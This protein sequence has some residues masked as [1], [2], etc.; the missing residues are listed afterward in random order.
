MN[1]GRCVDRTSSSQRTGGRVSDGPVLHRIV[2][3]NRPVGLPLLI[4]QGHRARPRRRPNPREA[5]VSARAAALKSGKPQLAISTGERA[6]TNPPPRKGSNRSCLKEKASMAL[7]R[8]RGQPCA[9]KAD[10]WPLPRFPGRSRRYLAQTSDR[11]RSGEPG[12]KVRRH[13]R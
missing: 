1:Q 9:T 7:L 8:P 11:G 4:E 5:R 6:V 3:K 2:V 10:P 12:T 13:S